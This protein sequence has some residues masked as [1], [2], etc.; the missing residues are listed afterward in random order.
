MRKITQPKA[1][2]CSNSFREGMCFYPA[3]NPC[4]P[5][6]TAYGCSLSDIDVKVV[7]LYALG[8]L[9]IQKPLAP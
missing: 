2:S 7:F 9:N 6:A 1:L 5:E 3:A 4:Y 8:F